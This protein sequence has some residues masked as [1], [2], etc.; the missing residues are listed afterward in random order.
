MVGYVDAS[1]IT[2]LIRAT[3]EAPSE[4]RVAALIRAANDNGGKVSFKDFV[5]MV[6]DIRATEG[7][8][9]L[10]AIEAAFRVFDPKGCGYLH[11]D[12][13]KR[14]LTSFG[15]KLSPE[16]VDDLLSVADVDDQGRVYY[17]QFAKK[18]MT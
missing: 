14:I 6:K 11:R 1:R 2:L 7:R 8:P 17:G 5:A 18:L 16:E 15:E 13:L 4:S 9:S 3:G 12:E 10:S